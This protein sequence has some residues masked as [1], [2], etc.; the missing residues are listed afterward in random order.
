MIPAPSADCSN[1]DAI[2][3]ALGCPTERNQVADLACNQCSSVAIDIQSFFDAQGQ[4]CIRAYVGTND[5]SAFGALV[6]FCRERITKPQVEFNVHYVSIYGQLS[7]SAPFG[8]S[9]PSDGIEGLG[10]CVSSG[11][12]GLDRAN[13]GFGSLLSTGIFGGQP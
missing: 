5:P 6:S 1:L 12:V 4:K 10:H 8:S 9:I 11:N 2:N 3:R 13:V 7:D